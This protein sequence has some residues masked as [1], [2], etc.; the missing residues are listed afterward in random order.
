MSEKVEAHTA[1]G[2]SIAAALAKPQTR[3]APGLILI[4]EWWGLNQEM[5][6]LAADFALH[7]FL[8]LAVDVFRGEVTDKRERAQQLMAGMDKAHAA[9]ALAT[10]IAWL[11]RQKDCNG[12]IGTLGYCLGGGWSLNASIANRVDATVVY[13]GLVDKKAP[14]L[15]SL[16]GP[17]LGHF[18]SKDGFATVDSAKAFEAEA[19]KAGKRVEIHVYDAD[20]AFARLKGPNYHAPSADLAAKRTLEFL[21][22]HLAP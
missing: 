15:A 20:H 14:E 17:V 13:Y 12:K 22:K 2:E 21:N 8:A 5:K 6:D 19:R 9:E 18:G 16:Q 1:S 7:G 10:W 11:R 4:H 3:P